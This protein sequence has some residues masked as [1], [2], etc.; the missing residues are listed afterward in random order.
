MVE[1][2]RP[3][4]HK[5]ATSCTKFCLIFMAIITAI[6]T[7]QFKQMKSADPMTAAPLIK[8]RSELEKTPTNE[9][10][11]KIRELDFIYRR[12]WFSSQEQF[13]YGVKV[14]LG[15]TILF[16][17]SVQISASTR[18]PKIK[19]MTKPVDDLQGSR[20]ILRKLVL[21]GGSTIL[22]VLVIAKLVQLIPKS[23]SQATLP[24]RTELAK[25]WVGFRGLNCLGLTD[26]HSLPT[27][28]KENI[29]WQ[30]KFESPGFSSPIIWQDKI[31]MTGGDT[32]SRTVTCY[33]EDGT[34]LW[35]YDVTTTITELPEVSDDTGF[36]AA[37]P[38]T[39]GVRIYATFATGDLVCLD[40][41]GQLIWQKNLGVPKNPYGY[42]SS[43]IIEDQKLIVQC[44]DEESQIIY[45]FNPV[46]GA[47]IWQTKRKSEI[48]WSSP[49]IVEINGQKI[50]VTLT[51]FAVE[52]FDLAT[53][54]Q[55]WSNEC[56]RGEVAPS[57]SFD[58][59]VIYVANDNACAAAID[60][61]TG[62][63]LWENEDIDLPD[64]S[65][66]I[67]VNDMVYLFTSGGIIVCLDSKT[68]EMLWDHETDEGFY[69]SAILVKDKIVA[70]DM[71]GIG[72]TITP[73]REKYIEI[74][75]NQFEE[76]VVATPSFANGRMYIR[77]MKTLYCIEAK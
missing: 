11:M 6:L 36:A 62:K 73:D 25:N 17:I 24:D 21:I 34:V 75:Q 32:K 70:I 12:A 2:K 53:G 14:L 26:Q 72:Y 74:E 77:G 68:G 64:V 10:K 46:N 67:V 16:L 30:T 69:S 27:K 31:I 45:A 9:L 47:I 57:I 22:A 35:K 13:N 7:M 50:V 37:T 49:G 5:T 20:K 33:G 59:K 18:P 44:D 42:S 8:L 3:I 55:L 38:T 29:L 15:V 52:G 4:I 43:L 71:A 48:G 76:G 65:S 60:P 23:T 51:C 1:S 40:F 41:S 61:L 54:K 56:M 66:P 39:D 19:K 63:S 28:W 58:G